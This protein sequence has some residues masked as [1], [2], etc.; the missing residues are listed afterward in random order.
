[1]HINFSVDKVS[2]ALAIFMTNGPDSGKAVWFGDWPEA[3]NRLKVTL[4]RRNTYRQA[5]I[6]YLRFCRETRQVATV[7][8]A[9]QFMAGIEGQRRLGEWQ[10]GCW[11]EALNWF[12]REAK[13]SAARM[14]AKLRL[15]GGG[16]AALQ[17]KASKVPTRRPA[18]VLDTP[19]L[20][21]EDLGSSPW[22]RKLIEHL[23]RG[24]YQEK[25]STHSLVQNEPYYGL[26]PLRKPECA[27]S[28]G[29]VIS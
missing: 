21:A 25:G 7:A 8:S 1:L 11:K 29:W 26:T 27:K 3:L 6:A 18:L 20:A 16:T 23:R 24:H 19:P 12:F 10:L 17:S 22:E 13:S 2:L 9:R 4:L 14:P 5:L 15:V 28:A